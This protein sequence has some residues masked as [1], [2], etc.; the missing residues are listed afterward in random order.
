MNVILGFVFLTCLSASLSG[1]QVN[2]GGAEGPCLSH[3]TAAVS[4]HAAGVAHQLDE[5]L[6]G[7]VLHRSEVRVLLDA[8]F[9]HHTHHLLTACLRR[10]GKIKRHIY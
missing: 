7:N 4:D 1:S 5:L 9:P 3:A 10:Q 2:D 8:L 6:K